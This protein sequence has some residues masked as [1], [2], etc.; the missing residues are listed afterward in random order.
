MKNFKQ[1]A[2]GTNC[3]DKGGP[4]PESNS[5]QNLTYVD[6]IICNFNNFNPSMDE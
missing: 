3:A 4:H 1:V 6:L 5:S 2:S